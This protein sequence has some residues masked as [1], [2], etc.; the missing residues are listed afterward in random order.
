MKILITGVAGFIGF[1]VAEYLLKK[2]YIVY[3]IDNFEKYYSPTLKKKRIVNLKKYKNFFF[4]KINICNSSILNKI[5]KKKKISTIIH[6]AAQ[7][8]VRYSLINP[9]KYIDNN[10]LGFFNIIEFAKL[11]KIK[12]II[13]ASSSSVYGDSNKFPLKEKIKLN[14]KNI[15]G[16]SKKINEEMAQIFEK[17]YKIKFVGL[18][19]FTVFGKWGRPDMF[20]FKL[21]KSL[22]EKKPFYLNNAG[23]HQRDF[24]FIDDVSEIIFRL[25]KKKIRNHK[26]YN[27]CSNNPQNIKNIALNFAKKNNIKIIMAP[28]NKADVLK[29]HGDNSNIKKLLKFYNFSNFADCFEKTFAWYRKE[30]IYKF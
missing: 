27:I 13:Y 6:F 9:K 26:I 30:K 28:L 22:F 15:Y 1:N 16:L 3:G 24:T 29:T 14:P 7:A 8:G 21:F 17:Q 18:R 23:N 4:K 10:I 2:N 12:K 5:L 25:I 19:F 11:N 20:I